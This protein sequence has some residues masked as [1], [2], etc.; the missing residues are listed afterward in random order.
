[1]HCCC[2]DSADAKGKARE[3]NDCKEVQILPDEWSTLEADLAQTA[4]IFTTVPETI[5]NALDVLGTVTVLTKASLE[6]TR[7]HAISK[8]ISA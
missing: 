4:S 8:T 1:L 2:E 5:G 3:S 6:K 7:D